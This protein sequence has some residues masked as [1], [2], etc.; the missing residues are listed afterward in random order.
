[1]SEII[2]C[3]TGLTV[4]IRAIKVREERILCVFRSKPN[5][6]AREAERDSDEAEHLGERKRLPTWMG[7]R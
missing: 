4:R 1:M 2:T 6:I 7:W 3:P 5:A